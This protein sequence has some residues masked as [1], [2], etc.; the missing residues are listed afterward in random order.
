MELGKPRF[1]VIIPVHNRSSYLYQTLRTCA[2]QNYENL[3]IIVSDDCSIDDT[4]RMVDMIY[5]FY[6]ANLMS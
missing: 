1:T 5:L 6:E 4:K 2:N 3:E